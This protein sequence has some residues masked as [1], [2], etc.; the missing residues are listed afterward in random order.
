M[1][2]SEKMSVDFKCRFSSVLLSIAATY[3]FLYI[4]IILLLLLNYDDG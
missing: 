4:L 3:I 2:K 1:E